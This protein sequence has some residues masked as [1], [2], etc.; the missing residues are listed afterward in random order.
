[1]AGRRD[2]PHQ[3]A[4]PLGHPAHHE[5]GRRHASRGKHFEERIGV[6]DHARFE[7]RPLLAPEARAALDLEDVE[8]VLDVDGQDVARL[9]QSTFRPPLRPRPMR[10]TTVAR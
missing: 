4:M 7:I 6:G 10:A 9:T 3:V 2:A 5:E 8:P 1:V